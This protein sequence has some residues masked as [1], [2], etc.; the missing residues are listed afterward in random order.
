MI[1]A[2]WLVPILISLPKSFEEGVKYAPGN[3]SELGYVCYA[4]QNG[5]RVL[6]TDLEWYLIAA[7]NGCI[8]VV[9]I[10]SYALIWYSFEKTVKVELA[11]LQSH[12]EIKHLRLNLIKKAGRING[13]FTIGIICFNY[14]ALRLPL[15][16]FT[17]ETVHTEI[18]IP[19]LVCNS[20]IFLQNSIY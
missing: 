5:T 17:Q 11:R 12:Q 2:V 6:F 8:F 9:L 13:S 10:V 14:I 4:V 7:N 15:V 3:G 1:F 19:L 18:S 20:V 16:T